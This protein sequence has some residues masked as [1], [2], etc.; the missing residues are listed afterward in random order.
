MLYFEGMSDNPYAN[1][2]SPK[3]WEK[4]YAIFPRNINGTWVWRDYYYRR[5]VWSEYKA[6][7]GY[8]DHEWRWEYG[9]LLDV[10]RA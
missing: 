7:D 5:M 9:T 2:V 1:D 8:T 4:R 3:P 10:L 6:G